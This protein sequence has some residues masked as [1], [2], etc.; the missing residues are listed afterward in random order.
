MAF[1]GWA[2]KESVIYLEGDPRNTD[3]RAE[4]WG[5]EGGEATAGVFL[6]TWGASHWRS[7]TGRSLLRAV[8]P[9]AWEWWGIGPPLP[10]ASRFTLLPV[11]ISSGTS[12]LQCPGREDSSD[13]KR[14]LVQHSLLQLEGVKLT[15]RRMVRVQG[16]WAG[17][18]QH[19]CNG[20]LSL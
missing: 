19:P 12:S 7:R 3:R 9:E 1:L 13:Q 16:M 4:K 20:I 10:S 8:L 17:Y 2:S 5:R 14:L 15:Y 18:Q 11:S 6:S